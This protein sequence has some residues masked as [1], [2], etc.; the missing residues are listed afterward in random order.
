MKTVHVVTL[1]LVCCFAAHA[2]F[3][4]TQTRKNSGGMMGGMM[5]GQ[6]PVSKHYLKGQKIKIDSGNTVMIMDMAAGT[7]TSINN[8]QKTYTVTNFADL[9][10]TMKDGEAEVQIDVKDTGQRKNINGFDSRQMIMTMS[11]ESPQAPGMKM[12]MEVET[13]LSK[14]VPGAAEALTFYQKHLWKARN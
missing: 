13:W 3:S 14:D 11:M 6:N 7:M 10:K 12:Q 1:A 2:D 4:Y 8:Q 5:Q 9:M